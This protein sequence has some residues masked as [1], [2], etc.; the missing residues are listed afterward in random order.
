MNENMSISVT[1]KQLYCVPSNLRAL[2]VACGL[3][4][5]QQFSGFNVLMYYSSTLFA[6]IGFENS[7]A[8]G[9]VVAATNFIFT[10]ISL[11]QI[12][13]IGRRR[14]LVFTMWGM[15]SYRIIIIHIY[16]YGNIQGRQELTLFDPSS[17]S[18]WW[19]LLLPFTGSLSTPTPSSSRQV[20]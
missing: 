19:L 2:I 17:L 10:L 9:T 18:R 14:I 20:M 12:D 6:S 16:S 7:I 8:V 13:R 15:V 3:M 4:A 11:W 1:L 5:I